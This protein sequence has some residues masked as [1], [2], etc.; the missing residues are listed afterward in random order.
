MACAGPSRGQQAVS[1][2]LAAYMQAQHGVNRFA[3]VVLVTRHDSVLL[4]QAYGLADYEWEVPH[5]LDSKFTLASITKHVTALAIMQLA[6]R[7]QLQLTDK[8]SAF[9][10]DFPNGQAISLHHLLTHTSGLALDFEAQYLDHTNVSRDS[11]LAV[12]KR[13]PVQFAPGTQISY[14]NVGYYLLGQ[15]VEKAGLFW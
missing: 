11:A 14:S 7:K 12:I 2:Q 10:P 6:E 8:L 9:F 4:H 5:T 1:Q 13:L 3:G 15:I